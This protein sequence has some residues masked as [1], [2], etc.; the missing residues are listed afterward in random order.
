MSPISRR[1]I[2]QA[3]GALTLSS[4]AGCLGGDS[5]SDSEPA[6]TPS[7]TGDSDGGGSSNG[8][9]SSDD[10]DDS[11]SVD[12]GQQKTGDVMFDP[13][14]ADAG[15]AIGA[16]DGPHFAPEEIEVETGDEVRWRFETGGHSISVVSQPD[17]ANW[18]GTDVRD[19]GTVVSNSFGVAGEYEYECGEHD[20][21]SATIIVT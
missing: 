6:S 18:Q 19:S 14:G 1:K 16:E 13:S 12:F 20:G 7:P 11:M 21:T 9:G 10:D 15:V 4:F 5:G 3:C 2:L 8:G 17:G